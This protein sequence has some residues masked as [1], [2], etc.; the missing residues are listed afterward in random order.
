M[1]TKLYVVGVGPGSPEYLLP[2]AH[3]I[4]RQAN[5]LIGG[6]RLLSQ[7]ADANQEQV[8]IGADLE[9]ALNYIERNWQLKLLVVL[10]S[11]DPGLYSFM[12]RVRALVGEENLEVI[13]GISP[14]Q[15]FFARIKQGWEGVLVISLHGRKLPDLADKVKAHSKVALLTDT[16]FP[17]SKIAEHL[18]RS[19][20][21]NRRVW[22]AQNLSYED[23]VLIDSD[24]ISLAKMS[25]FNNCVMIIGGAIDNE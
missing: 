17:P 23:E 6:R 21:A 25:D 19:G 22:V 7:Y 18:L 9:S 24:L 3:K 8:V 14:V 16:K 13:P 15:L 10:V 4:I 11:G 12:P 1:Q 2:V 20:V 5:V